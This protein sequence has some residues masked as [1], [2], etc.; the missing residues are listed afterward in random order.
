M[1]NLTELVKLQPIPPYEVKEKLKNKI[2][3]KF[4][5]LKE[6]LLTNNYRTIG[7]FT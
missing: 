5:I 4:T 1:Y 7:C 2:K 6:A 3:K